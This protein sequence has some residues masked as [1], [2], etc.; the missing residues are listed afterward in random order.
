MATQKVSGNGGG[1]LKEN[2]VYKTFYSAGVF[3][4][5]EAETE[6]PGA[7]LYVKT[8]TSLAGENAST[9]I[10]LES[11]LPIGERK[12]YRVLES[13]VDDQVMSRLLEEYSRVVN[14]PKNT[15]TLF[16]I[17]DFGQKITYLLPSF[18]LLSEVEQA[19][20]LFHEALWILNPESDYTAIIA[21]EIS[22]QRFVAM[23]SAGK[24]DLELPNFL[25]KLLKDPRIPFNSAVSSDA[26]SMAAPEI[27]SSNK[28]IKMK[29][30]LANNLSL[31]SERFERYRVKSNI[32][33][34][35][36][37]ESNYQLK[38]SLKKENINS[39]FVLIKKFP[40]SF[41]LKNLL[42]FISG[43]N[44]VELDYTKSFDRSKKEKREL[45]LSDMAD[46]KSSIMNRELSL[47]QIA[48]GNSRNSYSRSAITFNLTENTTEE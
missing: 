5:P 27:V 22:F 37:Y 7:D 40:K 30:L 8:I 19:A 18:Y 47:D 28:T 17:T 35:D 24:F 29:Y 44:E 36:T 25:K 14:Q 13:K 26:S 32:W 33:G 4:N 48:F 38:C 34:R 6:I 46:I 15:I 10:L 45:K 3:V 1:G 39:L 11:A 23:Q 31:C 20:I 9:S 2:G 16:A 42:D 21:A 43:G 12:F 41:M